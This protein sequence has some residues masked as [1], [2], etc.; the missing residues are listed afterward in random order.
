MLTLKEIS[1]LEPGDYIYRNPAK[2]ES[3]DLNHKVDSYF[4]V[5]SVN[6]EEAIFKFSHHFFKGQS[7]PKETWTL[8]MRYEFTPKEYPNWEIIK[9]GSPEAQGIEG[10]FRRR[11]ITATFRQC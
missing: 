4:K 9:K 2:V 6:C 7:L 1:Y 5:L 8:E 3:C 11:W 10:K